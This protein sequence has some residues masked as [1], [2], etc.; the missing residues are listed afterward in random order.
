ME[1]PCDNNEGAE[2]EIKNSDNEESQLS[3]EEEKERQH[4][5][6]I[7]NAFKYY[8]SVD[9]II[10]VSVLVFFFCS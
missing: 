1:A 7:I 5:I 6:R 9:S 3:E 4:F 10:F 2:N 8:K